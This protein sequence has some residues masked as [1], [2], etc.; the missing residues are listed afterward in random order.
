MKKGKNTQQ[1][2][3]IF[4]ERGKF[5]TRPQ[6]DIPRVAK[7]FREHNVKRVLDLGCGSGRHIIYL[8]KHGFEVYG[9][10]VAPEGVRLAKEWLTKSKLQADLKTGSVYEKLPYEDNFFDAVISIQVIH[11]ARITI[12][13]EAISEI[14]RVLRPNGLVFITV[15]KSATKKEGQW[16]SKKIEPRTI[17]PLEGKERGLTHYY[18]TKLLLRKEFKNFKIYDIWVDSNK[19]HYCLIGK[20]KT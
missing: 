20:L 19:R 17:I 14:E 16:E 8:A 5:F 12:I 13:R 6:E 7:T 2:N 4:K 10:D 11:H 9:I 1:W 3:K 18:F 15:A